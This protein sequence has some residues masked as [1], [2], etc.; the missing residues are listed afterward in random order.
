MIPTMGRGHATVGRVATVV[1][2]VA[3]PGA[4]CSMTSPCSTGDS[5]VNGLCFVPDFSGFLHCFDADTGKVWWTYDMESAMWG[6]PLA[7]DGKIYVTDEAGD[8][9]IFAIS[10]TMKKLSPEDDHLNLGEASYCSPV[11]ANGVLFLTDR[12]KLFAVKTG[13]GG[14]N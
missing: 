14:G 9:R 2:A 6:S 1:V 10:K 4:S 13:A 5:C 8:V 11:F 7:A 12:D 3:E